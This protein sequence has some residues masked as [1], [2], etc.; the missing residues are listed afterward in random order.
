MKPNPTISRSGI[1]YQDAGTGSGEVNRRR[2]F[3]EE[4]SHFKFGLGAHGS[5]NQKK[6]CC[7]KRTVKSSV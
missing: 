2:R 6:G 7:R 5:V 1:A 4:H 3:I